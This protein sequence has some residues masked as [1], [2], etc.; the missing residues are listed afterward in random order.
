M[1]V[2]EDS[3]SGTL[4]APNFLTRLQTAWTSLFASLFDGRRVSN[5]RAPQFCHKLFVCED[6][7]SDCKSEA[8]LGQCDHFW[9]AGNGALRRLALQDLD[10][11]VSGRPA[12]NRDESAAGKTQFRPVKK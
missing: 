8:L 3:N 9:G 10:G 4:T 2:G 7:P 6:Q 11:S 1:P 12:Q 5:E